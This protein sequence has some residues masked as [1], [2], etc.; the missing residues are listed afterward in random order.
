LIHFEKSDT[1]L[2]M[3]PARRRTRRVTATKAQRDL[4]ELL[5]RVSYGGEEFIIERRGRAVA[6]LG[7]APGA[8]PVRRGKKALAGEEFLAFLDGLKFT[9]DYRRT[10]KRL[11]EDRPGPRPPLRWG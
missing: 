6:R 10:V 2:A 9:D 3:A 11:L 7:P 8:R 5:S 1:L 4:S